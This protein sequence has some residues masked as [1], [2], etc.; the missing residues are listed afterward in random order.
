MSVCSSAKILPVLPA[1]PGFR[2]G[3]VTDRRL[4]PIILQNGVKLCLI[5]IHF[6]GPIALSLINKLKQKYYNYS[7]SYLQNKFEI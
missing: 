1:A 2:A 6:E 5:Q 3:N 4:S 7:K